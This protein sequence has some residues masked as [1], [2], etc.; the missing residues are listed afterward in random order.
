MMTKHW[1]GHT[2]SGSKAPASKKGTGICPEVLWSLII[3]PNW[4]TSGYNAPMGLFA[5]GKMSAQPAP[6]GILVY[7]KKAWDLLMFPR[8]F[9]RSRGQEQL[10]MPKQLQPTA[11]GSLQQ[12]KSSTVSPFFFL[13]LPLF[14]LLGH[15]PIAVISGLNTECS[16]FYVRN[17]FC[18]HQTIFCDKY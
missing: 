16:T 3:C 2:N 11:A 18:W 17:P 8:L 4:A 15:N 6:S 1:C 14:P 10:I 5:K 9:V 13:T 12:G 7:E